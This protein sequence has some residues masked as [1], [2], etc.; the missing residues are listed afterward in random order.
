M[1]EV[2]LVGGSG[3]T[4]AGVGHVEVWLGRVFWRFVGL[5]LE[6]GTVGLGLGCCSDGLWVDVSLV[7]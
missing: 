2:R 6:F 3:G 4:A 5:R 7:D 1:G